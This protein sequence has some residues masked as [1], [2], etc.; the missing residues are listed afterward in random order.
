MNK[1][2]QTRKRLTSA[3]IAVCAAFTVF[4]CIYQYVWYALP[5][6]ISLNDY[7]EA[8]NVAY[9]IETLENKNYNY[10]HIKGWI[11][12]KGNT[13]IQYDTKL[14][15]YKDGDDK[16]LAFPLKYDS[17]TDVT[18]TIA[19]GKNYE[20]SGF[21]GQIAHRYSGKGYKTGFLFDIGRQTCFYKTDQQYKSTIKEAS[22]EQH[23]SSQD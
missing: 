6:K 13:P 21:E 7:S 3:V 23:G 14:V 18:D 20:A 2:K 15:L 22:D 19:D 8:G 16:A 5:R 1:E 4:I 17:R 10:D 9:K 12:S 11:V